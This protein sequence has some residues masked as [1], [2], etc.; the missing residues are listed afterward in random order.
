LF[1][2]DSAAHLDAI[3][4]AVGRSDLAAAAREAHNLVSTA[5]N[6]GAM[7]LSAIAR[8]LEQAARRHAAADA[9]AAADG[10]RAAHT[11]TLAEI[12]DWRSRP[13]QRQLA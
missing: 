6:I 4:A 13:G 8:E 10:L 7:R 5:G 1:V 9:K 12:K 11:Q 3:E 2:Q